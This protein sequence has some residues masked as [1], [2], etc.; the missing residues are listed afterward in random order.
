MNK[1]R[2]QE[3]IDELK[4]LRD[5][6]QNAENDKEREE[7][8]ED[9]LR[10]DEEIEKE[11]GFANPAIRELK[12][13]DEKIKELEDEYD[14]LDADYNNA[15]DE[16]AKTEEDQDKEIS[17]AK[18]DEEIQ[19]ILLKYTKLK[20]K[21][22]E[23]SAKIEIDRNLAKRSATTL[24]G[25]RTKLRNAMKRA[26]LLGISYE[27]Y[28]EMTSTLGKS[29]LVNDILVAKGL[30]DLA[31]KDE[32]TDD[33]KLRIKQIKEEV[34]E[35]L[36]KYMNQNNHSSVLDSIETLYSV[37]VTSYRK[38][39]E[40]KVY[41][42]TFEDMI[43]MMNNANLLPERIIGEI[44]LDYEPKKAPDDMVVNKAL[45]YG[46]VYIEPITLRNLSSEEIERR[47][48]EEILKDLAAKGFNFDPETMEIVQIGAVTTDEAS[49][50]QYMGYEIHPKEKKEE[51]N[52]EV[53][54]EKDKNKVRTL[55]YGNVYIEPITLRGLSS[56]E[57]ER[58]Y[59]EEI[60]RDLEAQGF[61]F[62]P[63]TMEIVQ[64]GAVTT[65]EASDIQYMGYEIHSKENEN[66]IEEAKADEKEEYRD[67]TLT[68][69]NV[70]IE[71]ITLRGLSSEEV[72]RRYDEEI[73]RDLEAQGFEFDPDTM[74]IVQ[75]GAVTTDEASDIQYMGYEIHGRER[76]DNN[77]DD[78]TNDNTDENID[79]NT[80]ENIPD[81]TTDDTEDNT[82]EDEDTKDDDE[83]KYP[84]VYVAD[85]FP[86]GFT[87]RGEEKPDETIPEYEITGEV[88]SNNNDLIEQVTLYRDVDTGNFYIRRT[89]YDRFKDILGDKEAVAR[90]NNALCYRISAEDAEKLRNWQDNPVSPF[91][92]NEVD[93]KRNEK[94]D[95][96]QL[97]NDD[98]KIPRIEKKPDGNDDNN[99][100]DGNNGDD[101]GDGDDNQDEDDDNKTNGNEGN[102]GDDG[103][104][105]DD[106]GDGDDNQDEDD[107]DKTNGNDGNNGDDGD[108]GDGDGDQDDEEDEIEEEETKSNT[109]RVRVRSV[110]RVI[111]DLTYGLPL[112]I[113]DGKRFIARNINPDQVFMS[114]LRTGQWD[115]NVVGVVKSIGKA[116]AST[117]SKWSA[118][119][120]QSKKGKE[121]CA[122]V[123]KRL[124]E[125]SEEDLEILWTQYRGNVPLSDMN[126]SINPLINA[127][128][129][130]YAYEKMEEINNQIKTNYVIYFNLLG[131]IDEI[132]ANKDLSDKEKKRQKD[133]LMKKAAECVQ[134]I[135]DLRIEGNNF[136]S[137]GAHGFSEDIKA[138]DSFMNIMGRHHA[139]KHKY[140]N[141]LSAQKA[142]KE[143][144]YLEALANN[145]YEDAVN[146][147]LDYERLYIDN[148]KIKR[149][150]FGKKS[151]GKTY[152]SP[153]IQE[154]DYRPD[155]FLTDLITTVAVA[156]SAV[157]VANSIRTYINN[158]KAVRA[159]NDQIE[160]ANKANADTIDQAHQIGDKIT[161]TG[162][163]YI[164]GLKAQ[165][166]QNNLADADVSERGVLD[167]Q[168][169]T[170]ND[171]YHQLDPANHARFN[172]VYADTQDQINAITQN[173]ANN[174]IDK[175]TAIQQLADVQAT[176]NNS[177]T[178][179]INDYLQ[180]AVDY[181]AAHPQHDLTAVIETMEYLAAHPNAINA[182]TDA[183]V[184]NLFEAA[185]LAGLSDTQ[186]YIFTGLDN[187]MLTTILGAATA[188]RLAQRVMNSTGKGAHNSTSA[189]RQENQEIA[190]MFDKRKNPTAGEEEEKG[191]NK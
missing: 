172:N 158:S 190:D 165:A 86:E 6:L 31:D 121:A 92:L 13:L 49:D 48:D 43:R 166:N 81:D 152:Y 56:E 147:F 94:T 60:I 15:N 23:K 37:D 7:I 115:Y 9:I 134:N 108:D 125:L 145:E 168:N 91:V 102:N 179:V 90:I 30:D 173:L 144:F 21:I 101:T 76:I 187:D 127:R 170:F 169:W 103:D 133:A 167:Q 155:P 184:D 4:Q 137:G 163:K 123:E 118:K 122:E 116:V 107:E 18:S 12:Y 159:H 130:R 55:K 181:A 22:N 140:D 156:A 67:V 164:D 177:L 162:D 41:K 38:K 109:E 78:N 182:M 141:E 95:D 114:E 47:Y 135:V 189:V 40:P 131:K 117:F 10:V 2:V 83:F 142:D 29:K 61:E 157:S 28:Q 183:G 176:A 89:A 71:P 124:N 59:D 148:T 105:G 77:T 82:N 50:I 84:A 24:K 62:D 54:D 65:D 3:L 151:V 132:M 58:R 68:Y 98:N 33:D 93:I 32:L 178:S 57:V 180:I 36:A 79:D 112:G 106:T 25:K 153:L 72:E 39:E 66:E 139:K 111:D 34:E 51:I 185:K 110:H 129:Q 160:Q 26:E 35:E 143:D 99:G 52:E 45:T 87:P 150:I 80:D 17:N 8:F 104:D 136:M 70:Y 19:E 171:A 174:K 11:T 113:K 100:D 186:A 120:L 138:A 96:D 64:V 53:V 97:D 191:R 75:T 44:N 42:M 20:S 175:M 27:E 73:I 69:G 63:N 74:E 16:Y 161:G 149:G 46:N 126:V 119:L 146:G 85:K 154:L 5:K 188:T 14:R 88:E 1:E 128:M